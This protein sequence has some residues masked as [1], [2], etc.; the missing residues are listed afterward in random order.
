M[1]TVSTLGESL[2][3][4]ELSKSRRLELLVLLGVLTAFAPLSIDMY[5]PALPALETYFKASEGAVQLTLALFIV[6]FSLGQTL[7][8][9]LTDRFGRKPPLYTGMTVY[10]L[11]SG[12]C[13]L[14][15]SVGALTELRLLQALGACAASVISRAMVRDLFPPNETRRVY[16]A[17]ILVM[18]V[19]PLLA[20]LFGA[21][22]LLWSGWKAIFLSMMTVGACAMLAMLFRLPETLPELRPLSFGYVFATYGQL[23]KD[24]FF[25]GSTLAAAFSSAGMFA[26]IAGS[27]FVFINLYGVRPDH[28]SWFFG[29]N[30]AAV[31]LGAQVNGR[32]LHGQPPEKVMRYAA[33][34]QAASGAI[35]I[36]APLIGIKSLTSVALP[37]FF[38]LC[39]IGFVSPNAVALALANHGRVAGMASA[40]LG[41]L[42]FSMAGLALLVLGVINSTTAFP[43]SA[44]ICFCGVMGV[45]MHLL[46]LRPAGS[47]GSHGF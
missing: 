39:T 27:P 47:T 36:V 23:L 13:T 22:I 26:Y 35:L 1:A 15:G 32:M 46:L 31:V 38:Y 20:P 11:S 2:P 7:Y 37:L 3:N 45:A 12:A 42:Q 44:M 29:A 16:S 41:T 40:L 5:L 8:G 33:Y 30:A 17:L 34:V 10:V 14:A 24:R 19:S 43:M 25:L 18:G 28:F 4:P 9:P 21:Y 6:G